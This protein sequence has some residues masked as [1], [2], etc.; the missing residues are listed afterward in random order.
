MGRVV[1]VKTG[2]ALP[3]LRSAR[4][5]FEDWILSGMGIPREWS[6]VVDVA[7]GEPLPDRRGLAGVVITGSSVMVTGAAP[8]SERT[9]QWLPPIV[10]AGI[11]VLGICYGHQ[12]LAHALG[13]AVGDNPRGREFGT[14]EVRLDDVAREDALLRAFP[15][16]MWLHVSHAQSVLRLPPHARH[17]AS[18]DLDPVQAF[19]VGERAWGVQF[20]PE[21]DAAIV[22]AYIRERHEE[23]VAQGKDPHALAAS[24]RD[25]PHGG[26]LLRRFAQI[27]WDQPPEAG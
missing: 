20:H 17:L 25:G 3:A 13:G 27:L 19:A 23:L 16:S 5:D 12:L 2:S 24:C 6:R 11:P 18:S 8:W 26:L 22:R 15:R 14:V 21:F 1:I 10:E 9:A 7:G 4:G